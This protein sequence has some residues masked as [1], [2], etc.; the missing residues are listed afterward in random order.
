MPVLR[1]D[2]FA[3][4]Q[5]RQRRY[6]VSGWHCALIFV[7]IA[8]LTLTRLEHPSAMQ[9]QAQLRDWSARPIGE[10]RSQLSSVT[11]FWQRLGRVFSDSDTEL[12]SLRAEN[13]DLARWKSRAQLLE[14]R[15][16]DVSLLV[17][18][19]RKNWRH[20]RLIA[21]VAAGTHGRLNRSLLLQSGR[22]DGIQDGYPVFGR[23]GL[24][25]RTFETTDQSARV[26][27]L[28]DVNSRVPV[29]V[30]GNRVRAVASGDGGEAARLG[31]IEKRNAVAIGD[32]VMTSGA[33]GVFPAGLTV[34]T[35][36]AKDGQFVVR[37]DSR[38]YPELY[39]EL[40]KY[41][42]PGSKITGFMAANA[43]ERQL[44]KNVKRRT[45]RGDARQL[46][47]RLQSEAERIQ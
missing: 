4:G 36:V 19:E 46:G 7:A 29:L 25:G 27:L 17:G 45:R 18:Q 20:D 41:S 34:G 6:A 8:L 30:G 26:L 38:N 13:R 12:Q 5:L 39:V 23:Y 10:V 22:S 40:W 15:L 31:Y 35:V 28:S 21:G 1:D 14:R 2:P 43:F 42:G 24:L 9:L 32:T 3:R 37:L 16:D 44:Q 11:L 33:A 47:A